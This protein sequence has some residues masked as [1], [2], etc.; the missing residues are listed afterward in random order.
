MLANQ[1]NSSEPRISLSRHRCVHQQ[2]GR[3]PCPAPSAEPHLEASA[4]GRLPTSS[5]T[6][7]N[8][9][10]PSLSL[11][12]NTVA[13]ASR[14]G[15]RIP[16]N[17]AQECSV[18]CREVRFL[19]LTDGAIEAQR[20]K[21]SPAGPANWAPLLSSTNMSQSGFTRHS[22][23]VLEISQTTCVSQHCSPHIISLLQLAPG[24]PL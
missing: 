20:K 14:D 11:S 4:N 3:N 10:P 13:S 18:T 22:Q 8:P 7:E 9:H 2:A 17:K 19:H 21:R 16:W 6:C 5:V 12:I 23:E 24:Q 1:L 15:V